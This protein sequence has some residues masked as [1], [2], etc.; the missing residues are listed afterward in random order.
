MEIINYIIDYS[1]KF[2]ATGGI[3][4]GFLLVFIECFIPA[5]PLSVFVALNVN[6]F[7][8][9]IGTLISWIATC[10]GSFLCYLLFSFL[11]E[12]FISKWF[13]NKTKKLITKGT[14]KFKT[15]GFSELVLIITLP[16]TPSFLVNILSG[17]AGVSKEKFISALLIGKVFTI[18]FWGY[19]GKSFI[20]S[21]TDI[22]SIFYIIIALIISYI[23]SKIVSRKMNIE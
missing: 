3:P 5:L 17:I 18:I 10:L 6:A 20:E 15:I 8:V 19:I 16:F 4:F 1:T 11:E 13:N 21:I 14:L 22:S 2:I 23:L 7:G 12:K 9:F